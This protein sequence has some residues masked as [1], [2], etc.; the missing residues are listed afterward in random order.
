MELTRRD[1]LAALAAAGIGGTAMAVGLN[2]ENSDSDNDG[3]DSPVGSTELDVLT[4]AA[5]VLYPSEVSGID[6]FVETFARGR[7]GASPDHAT[8]VADAARHVDEWSRSWF[9]EGYASLDEQKREAALD[10]IGAREAEPDPQ[11]SD[12]ERVRYYLVNELLFALYSS[13][14]GGKLAGIENPQGH[15]GGTSSYSRGPGVAADQS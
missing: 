4:G 9:D 7:E 8:G 2:G 5:E 6:E 15:P 13:P 12:S 3:T 14:T 10:R 1:A 11:G